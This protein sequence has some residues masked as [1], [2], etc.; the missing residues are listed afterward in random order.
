MVLGPFRHEELVVNEKLNVSKRLVT[1]ARRKQH[2]V[3]GGVV[4][5][6]IVLAVSIPVMVQV[7]VCVCVG[8]L[9]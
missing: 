2:T 3:M 8:V 6:H 7:C 5:V 9:V 4:A 1:V